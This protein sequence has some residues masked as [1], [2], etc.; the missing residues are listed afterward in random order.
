[1]KAKGSWGPLCSFG[2]A[3][4]SPDRR[5]LSGARCSGRRRPLLDCG[6]TA[7][8]RQQ[9]SF[10]RVCTLDGIC[11]LNFK[12]KNKIA[13]QTRLPEFKTKH[14][15]TWAVGPTVPENPFGAS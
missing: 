5:G 7:G 13:K 4:Q 8:Q 3:E 1:M 12:L 6:Q 10:R 2:S 15:K 11:S 14:L 9:A